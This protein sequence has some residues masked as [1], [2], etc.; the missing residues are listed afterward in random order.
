MDIEQAKQLAIGQPVRVTNGQP[1][2][3]ER[4]KRK[5]RAWESR[6]YDGTV[7]RLELDSPFGPGVLVEAPSKSIAGCIKY[8]SLEQIANVEL[9]NG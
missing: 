8:T 5:L 6:N 3:P 9:R 4:H 1:R 7:E 2:P